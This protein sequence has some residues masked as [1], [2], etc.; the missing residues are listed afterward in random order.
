MTDFLAAIIRLLIGIVGLL[1]VGALFFAIMDSEDT[2]ILNDDKGL[3]NEYARIKEWKSRYCIP[4]TYMEMDAGGRT[5]RV[6]CS[7]RGSEVRGDEN[8]RTL[9]GTNGIPQI[10]TRPSSRQRAGGQPP[11]RETWQW[12]KEDEAVPWLPPQ[13]P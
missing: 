13:E 10:L 1:F 7:S 9:S 6:W 11:V 4:N 5:A 8:V 3:I 12:T 2:Q